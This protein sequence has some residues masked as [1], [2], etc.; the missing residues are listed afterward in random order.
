MC[1]WL[2]GDKV[3]QL[4]QVKLDSANVANERGAILRMGVAVLGFVSGGKPRRTL[5]TPMATHFISNSVY[6]GCHLMVYYPYHY[7]IQ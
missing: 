1:L 2:S 6:G 5:R 3:C 4:Q 7:M